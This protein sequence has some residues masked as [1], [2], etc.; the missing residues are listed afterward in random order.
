MSFVKY[1]KRQQNFSLFWFAS[2]CIEKPD[3]SKQM[4]NFRERT[5]TECVLVMKNGPSAFTARAHMFEELHAE[6]G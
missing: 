1:Q 5:K 4:E 2:K 3:C 6:M